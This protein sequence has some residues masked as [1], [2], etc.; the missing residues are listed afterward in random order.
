MK[1]YFDDN[2][3]N[4]WWFVLDKKVIYSSDKSQLTQYKIS[5][6]AYTKHA[7]FYFD[8]VFSEGFSYREDTDRFV[9]LVYG[10]EILILDKEK[11]LK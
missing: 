7:S 10:N 2:R 11:E 4:W 6:E 3:F 1:L 5:L 9:F 8:E